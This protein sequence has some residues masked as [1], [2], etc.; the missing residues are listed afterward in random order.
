MRKKGNSSETI[1]LLMNFPELW[2]KNEK[3]MINQQK[4]KS[5][6][7]SFLCVAIGVSHEKC[8]G[9]EGR[10]LTVFS[11]VVCVESQGPNR[12]LFKSNLERQILFK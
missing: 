12:G 5:I 2:K 1:D 6:F 11:G 7:F 4:K 9:L 10:V 8:S 3:N